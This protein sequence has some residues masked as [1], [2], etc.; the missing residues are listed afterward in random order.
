VDDNTGSNTA[1]VTKTRVK[2]SPPREHKVIFLNDE[3]TPMEFV[4]ESLI[5]VFDH[6]NDT[7][8]LL[9]QRIHKEGSAVVAVLPFEIAEHKGVE[10]T[11]FARN[12]GF[13][14]Q[15]KIEPE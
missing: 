8:N 15:V 2:L 1:V 9:T 5:G 7:A 14:L 4:V 6:D 11:I 10:V 12:N 3:Y 13:P